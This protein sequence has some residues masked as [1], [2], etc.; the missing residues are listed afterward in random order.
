ML[1]NWALP[2][3]HAER[4]LAWLG[5]RRS[6]LDHTTAT[7]DDDV[8]LEE[9]ACIVDELNDQFVKQTRRIEAP[10]SEGGN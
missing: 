7:V 2:S 5:M 9:I 8:E 4:V 10:A 1:I 6:A 3:E